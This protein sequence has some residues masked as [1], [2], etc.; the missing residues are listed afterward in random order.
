MKALFQALYDKAAT[1][2]SAFFT[3]IGGRL[4]VGEAPQDAALP[5][6][7]LSLT[8]NPSDQLMEKCAVQLSLFSQSATAGEVCDLYAAATALY[9][10]ADI[11]A[12]GAF[13]NLGAE[14]VSAFLTRADGVWHYVIEYEIWI[15]R[16]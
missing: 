5:F 11:P 13:G 16:K 15:P 14:R 12:L 4:Y 8:G 10:N 3:A 9:D 6:A 7:V 1:P 2:P